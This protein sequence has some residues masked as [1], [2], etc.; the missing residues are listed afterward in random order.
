[1]S[2][3]GFSLGRSFRPRISASNYVVAVIYDRKRD[4]WQSHMRVCCKTTRGR[5]ATAVDEVLET[6]DLIPEVILAPPPLEP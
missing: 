1:M 4:P 5:S 2:P 6:G 3:F